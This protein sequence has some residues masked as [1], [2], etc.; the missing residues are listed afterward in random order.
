MRTFRRYEKAYGIVDGKRTLV[1]VLVQ[2]PVWTRATVVGLDRNHG[3]GVVY[4]RVKSSDL[5]PV[6]SLNEWSR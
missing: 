5:L 6:P 4:C 3:Q 2:S 1:M